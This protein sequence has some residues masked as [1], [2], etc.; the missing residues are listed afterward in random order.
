[1]KK[2]NN[3]LSIWI[4]RCLIGITIFSCPGL[5]AT[6]YKPVVEFQVGVCTHFS[7]N[8]GFLEQN[9]AS[10]RVAGI[11]AIRDE[12]SWGGMEREKGKLVIPESYDRYVRQ[13]SRAGIQVMLIL[14]YAN[15][16]YDGGDRPRSPEAIEGYCRY[17]EFVVRHFG[18]D[19][20]LY[21]IWNEYDIGIG[22]PRQFNKGGSPKDYMKMLKSVYPRIKAIHPNA[23]V[24][25]GAS[26]SGG[27]KRGWLEK[28]IQLG[29][30]QYSDAISIHSYNYSDKFPERGPE[31]CSAW[32]TSVQNMLKKYNNG[33]EVPF[34]VT[35]MGWP[36]HVGKRGT[37]PELSASYLARLYLLARTSKSFRGIWWYDFQD[38]GWNAEH[39]ENNFGIV[40][41]DLTPKPSYYVMA[42]ISDL[43]GRG[44]YLDRLKTEDDQLWILR[45]RHAGQDVWVMWSGDN[46]E[47]QV[48]FEHQKPGGRIKVQETGRKEQLRAWGYREWFSREKKLYPDR[49]SI[50]AGARPVLIQ[51]NLSGASVIQIISRLRE[52]AK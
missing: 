26:T 37:E 32:M 31:A 12:V 52:E 28:I 43:I 22:L 46:Q 11:D 35:E 21:E 34:Y 49:L 10:L 17:A 4:L 8:K 42:D 39:N 27:V 51:G 25:A 15:R 47:R 23:T 6:Q 14:D 33:K 5:G 48:V 30:L 36:T 20:H 50:V 19:V 29:A 1:M 2:N 9:L 44:Q 3:V 18:D 13:M 7:Q 40:R 41:P 24:I 16:H 45:F 38:D